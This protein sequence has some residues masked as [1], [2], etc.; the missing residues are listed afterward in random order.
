MRHHDPRHDAFTQRIGTD[1]IK[2]IRSDASSL[3]NMQGQDC[4]AFSMEWPFLVKDGRVAIHQHA[5]NKNCMLAF[6]DL[7]QRFLR[8][9]SLIEIQRTERSRD[10]AYVRVI[11]LLAGEGPARRGLDCKS[12]RINRVRESIVFLLAGRYEQNTKQAEY[13]PTAVGR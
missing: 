7:M 12:W 1:Y 13:G 5:S 6:A 10:F 9:V 3:L 8:E 2:M 11:S 4:L